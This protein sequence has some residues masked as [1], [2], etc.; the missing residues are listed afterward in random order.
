MVSN[1]RLNADKFIIK[2]V[3]KWPFE[4][5]YR[6]LDESKNQILYARE[7]GFFKQTLV[8]FESEKSTQAI[9]TM[10][11][12]GYLLTSAFLLTDF[13]GQLF[14]KFVRRMGLFSTSFEILA[15]QSEMTHV[16]E[17][18]SLWFGKVRFYF[19]GEPAGIFYERVKLSPDWILDLSSDT[20]RQ[21][22]RRIA[23]AV[24][25]FLCQ[26]IRWSWSP[27]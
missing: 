12:K 24:A 2:P 20:S 7:K 6:I 19:G 23:V 11:R 5:G 8:V 14:G 13:E 27:G 26:K 18:K 1:L 4:N 21:L 9:F 3:S 16:G 10:Q 22:D 17:C 15:G 25:L